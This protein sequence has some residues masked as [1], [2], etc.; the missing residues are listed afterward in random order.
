ME[1]AQ[2]FE[3]EDR[4]QLEEDFNYQDAK[5]PLS[6]K[7]RK[8]T[9]RFGT[10]KRTAEESDEAPEIVLE[11]QPKSL[12]VKESRL[13]LGRALHSVSHTIIQSGAERY[14]MSD[15][16]L[17]MNPGL[18]CQDFIKFSVRAV[19]VESQMEIIRDQPVMVYNVRI[20]K[21]CSPQS[22]RQPT[23]EHFNVNFVL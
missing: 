10:Q 17:Q 1:D 7:L 9:A 4:S 5:A 12:G 14:D 3:D 6:A 16:I 20:E 19:S 11:V 13:T 8:E 23:V 15:A 18:S 22:E 2:S 21:S